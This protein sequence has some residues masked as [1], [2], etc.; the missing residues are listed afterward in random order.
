VGA[1]VLVGATVGARVGELDPTHFGHATPPQAT[2]T[3]IKII[4]YDRVS[5]LNFY[6]I[7]KLLKFFFLFFFKF[8]DRIFNIAI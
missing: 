8:K 2:A 5:Y 4:I 1:K 7:N 6:F 3:I